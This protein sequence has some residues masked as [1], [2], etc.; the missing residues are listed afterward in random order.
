MCEDNRSPIHFIANGPVE[1]VALPEPVEERP[2]DASLPAGGRDAAELLGAA[3][4]VEALGLCSVFEGHR[5]S[6]VLVWKQ[7]RRRNAP[8]TLLCFGS[9]V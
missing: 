2:R 6:P 1:R 5:A 8:L 4:D 7:E 9:E 3:E